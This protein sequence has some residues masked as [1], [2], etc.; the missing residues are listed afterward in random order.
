MSDSIGSTTAVTAGGDGRPPFTAADIAGIVGGAVHGDSGVVVT[1]VAPLD[2]ANG[3]QLSFLAG[4]R[5]LSWFTNTKAG[6]VITTPALSER[7]TTASALVVV[8]KPMDAMVRLLSYFHQEDQRPAGIHP[9]AVIAS[10]AVLG[11]DVTIGPYAVIEE[12]VV[13]GN[14]SWIGAHSVVGANSTLGNSVR[15]HPGVTVYP[16]VE[17][18]N[19]VIL[20]AGARVGREGFGFVPTPDGVRRIPHVGR[21]VLSDDVEVGANSCVDRGSVDDTVIGAGTKIDSLVQ[22]GHNVRIGRLCFIA[23]Q[24]G[25]AGSTRIG[26]GVQLG[27]QS[28]ISGHVELGDGVSIAAQAGVISDIPAG[29]TWS[30]YPARPHRE[31][32]RAHA[33]LRRL[34]QVIRPLETLLKGEEKR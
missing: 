24:A 13:I 18:G 29:E 21:C 33:A 1:G 31:Q 15:I 28:G 8:E 3:N 2:R 32:L 19:R 27:G 25:L 10:S 7:K 34:T 9:S 20:H 4:E 17:I 26:D 22:V 6:V 30:G 12:G 23:S 5:Y 16:R 11:E 14:G